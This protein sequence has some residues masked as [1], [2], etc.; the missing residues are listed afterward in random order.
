MENIDRSCYTNRGEHAMHIAAG[1]G[2]VDTVRSL[3]Q[4][5]YE[6]PNVTENA[7]RMPLMDSCELKSVCAGVA[8][9]LVDEALTPPWL[10]ESGCFLSMR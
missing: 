2:R 5:D 3:S 10:W 9:L 8:W 4:R 7:G 6:D 1:V